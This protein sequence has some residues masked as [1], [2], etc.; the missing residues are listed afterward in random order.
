M[1]AMSVSLAGP[2]GVSLAAA[3]DLLTA[4]AIESASKGAQLD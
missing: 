2:E 3:S 4:G 1:S